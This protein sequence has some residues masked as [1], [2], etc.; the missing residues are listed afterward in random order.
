[1]NPKL[2]LVSKFGC[3]FAVLSLLGSQAAYSQAP[4]EIR[5]DVPGNTND[6]QTNTD[7]QGLPNRN[8]PLINNERQDS[9]GAGWFGLLGLLGLGGL[10][11]KK[12]AYVVDHNHAQERRVG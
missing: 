6:V 1:M 7:P 5:P 3:T 9:G 11:Y 4:N 12:E 2:S 10:F 8:S